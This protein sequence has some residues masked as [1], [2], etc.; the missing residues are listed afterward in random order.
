METFEALFSASQA[1]VLLFLARNTGRIFFEREIVDA[2]GVSR[3]A[4]NMATQSLRKTSLVDR[5]RRGRMNFYA[6][7]DRHPFVRQ[8]KILDT[9]VSLES[10]LKDLRPLSRQV[11]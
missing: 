5:E 8:F 6:V 1:R 10:V 11:T 2:T 7:N 3:S 9:L 4:V